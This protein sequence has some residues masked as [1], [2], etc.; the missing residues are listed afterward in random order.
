MKNDCRTV[1]S[2]DKTMVRWATPAEFRAKAERLRTFLRTVSDPA[3]FAV[4]RVIIDELEGQA[5]AAGEEDT[6][7]D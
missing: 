4:I 3:E 1:P 5:K 6:T 2:N 7:G